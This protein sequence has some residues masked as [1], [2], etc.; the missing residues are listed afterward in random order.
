MSKAN[1]NTS[2]LRAL[3]RLN[4]F[5]AKNKFSKQVISSKNVICLLITPPPRDPVFDI[6]IIHK[7]YEFFVLLYSA[8]QHFP[9]KDRY[10]LGQKCEQ[11]TLELLEL[12][13]SAN[14][15]G[16]ERPVLQKQADLKLKILKTVIRLAFD[17]RAIDQR[18]YLSLEGSIIEIGRMLGGWIKKTPTMQ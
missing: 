4:S 14:A 7:T 9:K 1:C 11:L 18:R 3:P 16:S 10:T 6:S 15:A 13:L 8:T 5:Q 17:V 12:L 2:F